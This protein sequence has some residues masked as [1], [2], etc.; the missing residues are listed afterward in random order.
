MSSILVVGLSHRSAP[1]SLL[2]RTAVT[3]DELVKLLHDVH[4][5]TSVNGAFVVSTCNRIEIYADVEKFHA[6][7]SSI[8]ELLARHSGVPLD[9]LSRHLYVHYEERAVH[10][11]FSVACGLDSMV[12]GE[13][14]ISGQLRAALKLAQANETVDRALNELVQQAL[15]VGKRARNETGIDRAG[16]SLVS[17][18]LGRAGS[19][20]GKRALVVGAGSMSSLAVATL[21]REGIGEIVI[22]NRTYERGAHLARAAEVPARAIELADVR[23]ELAGADI[24]VSCTGAIGIV[25]TPDM[26]EG[27]VFLLDLALPHDV[28]PAVRELSGVTLVGLDDLRETDDAPAVADTEAV[29]RIVCEEVQAFQL[30]LIAATVA[31]TVVALRSK[32]AEVVDAELVRLGGRL[33]GLD[34]RARDEVAQTVRRVVDK[35]LHA[36]TVRVKELAASPDGDTYTEALRELFDLDPKTPEA[37]IRAEDVL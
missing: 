14:Q 25:I 2:E 37:V 8:S 31:P 13:G 36:P 4:Q 20:T 29:R 12:V 27:P 7:V 32:A 21:A 11:I 16:A 17:V 22:A 9:E 18:G 5:A 26:I 30:G 3:A 6:G 35:L 24:V 33:P 28:D 1:V 34:D 19:L 15:R 23:A 10:H